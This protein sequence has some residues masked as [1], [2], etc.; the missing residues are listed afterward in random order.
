LTAAQ[1]RDVWGN[2]DLVRDGIVDYND[3]AVF[4]NEELSAITGSLTGD[5]NDDGSVTEYDLILLAAQWLD[6]Y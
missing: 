6:T 1:I 4:T 3:F 5:I 2:A